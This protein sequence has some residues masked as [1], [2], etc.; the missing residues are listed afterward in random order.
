KVYPSLLEN[1][2]ALAEWT[3]GTTL[4]PYLER[5][6]AHLKEPFM[7]RYR[8]RLRALHP[9]GSVFYPFRRTLFAATR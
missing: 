2:D 7:E 5:L 3:R 8:E 4:V 9:P 6:P 1:A